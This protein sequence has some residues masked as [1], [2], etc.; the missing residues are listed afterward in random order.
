M[1]RSLFRGYYRALPLPS[2]R[3]PSSFRSTDGIVHLLG[4]QQS[5]SIGIV[6]AEALSSA[7][8]KTSDGC[9][10]SRSFFLRSLVEERLRGAYKRSFAGCSA[11]PWRGHAQ[12]A[13]P[14]LVF[15][16]PARGLAGRASA[17]KACVRGNS[18]RGFE[19]RSLRHRYRKEALIKPGLLVIQGRLQFIYS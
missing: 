4:S 19:S 18:Y 5:C 14:G 1:S 3:S 12:I 10:C 7:L 8:Q 11:W 17:W 2:K 9:C 13:C 15:A 16:A 6:Q